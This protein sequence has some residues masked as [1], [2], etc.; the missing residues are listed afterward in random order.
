MERLGIYGTQF[1]PSSSYYLI[2]TYNLCFQGPTS[3][4]VVKHQ[5]MDNT[6]GMGWLVHLWSSGEDTDWQGIHWFT[7]LYSHANLSPWEHHLQ[8]WHHNWCPGVGPSDTPPSPQATGQEMRSLPK[9]A[10]KLPASEC[11]KTK[12]SSPI[13]VFTV[14]KFTTRKRAM[15]TLLITLKVIPFAAVKG[16]LRC[17]LSFLNYLLI[18][19]KETLLNSP[20]LRMRLPFWFLAGSSRRAL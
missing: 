10:D 11:Q 7:R 15:Q 4:T 13:S 20:S 6:A 3:A 1:I 18:L 19:S 12:H 5:R 8:N 16:V 2:S 9:K 17:S 14:R